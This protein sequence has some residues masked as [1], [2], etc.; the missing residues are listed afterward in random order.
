MWRVLNISLSQWSGCLFSGFGS[1][2]AASYAPAS[3]SELAHFSSLNLQRL[4]KFLKHRLTQTPVYKPPLFP[5]DGLWPWM[6]TPPAKSSS[7]ES[8]S[9]SFTPNLALRSII[10]TEGL[11]GVLVLG[12]GQNAPLSS[13]FGMS[14]SVLQQGA[15]TGYASTVVGDRPPSTSANRRR[16]CG[17]AVEGLGGLT[18]QHWSSKLA[19]HYHWHTFVSR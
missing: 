6:L 1:R 9:S 4:C 19:S 12:S 11:I 14:I 3:T 18:G 15:R 2:T 8:P 13:L 10:T 16:G 5:L 7:S 17:R